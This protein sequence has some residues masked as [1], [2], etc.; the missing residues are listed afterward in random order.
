MNERGFEGDPSREITFGELLNTLHTLRMGN[1][2]EEDALRFR[3]IIR[4]GVEKGV[5]TWK[6]LKTSDD[7]LGEFYHKKCREKQQLEWDGKWDEIFRKQIDEIRQGD[8]SW[9]YQKIRNLMKELSTRVSQGRATW[10]RLGTTEE[11]LNALS[12]AK[13]K[14][15][16]K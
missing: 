12:K 1:Y 4:Q 8:D 2:T 14:H 3:E 5:A 16:A 6:Q 10:E 11:E 9:G 7:E 15:K 13:I